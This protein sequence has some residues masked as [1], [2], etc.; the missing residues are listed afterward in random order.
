MEL[1]RKTSISISKII[2][3]SYSTSFSAGMRLLEPEERKAIYAIYGFVRIADEIVDTFHQFD[4]ELLLKEFIEDTE[5]AIERGISSNPV[6]HS[7]QWAFH[8]YN[9]D[10]DLV[11]SFFASMEMDLT[12]HRYKN[13][14][15]NKYIYGSAEVV[16]LM[17][18]SVFYP[19]DKEYYEELVPSARKLG[20]AFQKVNFLRDI[21][22]DKE[23]RDRIYFPGIL[24][25]SIDGVTKGKIENDIGNDFSKALP[26]I[27]KLDKRIALGVYLAYRYYFELFRKIQRKKPEQLMQQRI[28]LNGFQKSYLF[29]NSFIRYRLGRI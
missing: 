13:E 24:L 11:D 29:L 23:E 16:G 17:C 15:F 28:R 25:D 18:L 21:K 10:K 27:R 26:G 12:V 5:L 6:L 1:Y 22:S 19:E 8:K 9:I 3:E 14:E 20:E 2:A 4:Q 7:F